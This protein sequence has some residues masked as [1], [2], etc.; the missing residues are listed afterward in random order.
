L[1]AE[2]TKVQEKMRDLNVELQTAKVKQSAELDAEKAAKARQ[3]AM[4]DLDQKIN[5]N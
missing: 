1:I 2:K 4:L 5:K 3:Y